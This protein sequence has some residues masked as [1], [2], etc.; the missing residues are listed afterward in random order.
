MLCSQSIE[1]AKWNVLECSMLFCT[2]WKERSTAWPLNYV[3]VPLG[4]RQQQKKRILNKLF[5]A[6]ERNGTKRK[7]K[8]HKGNTFSV[9]WCWCTFDCG[10]DSNMICS[11]WSIF[12]LY[13]S[14]GLYTSTQRHLCVRLFV[15]DYFFVVGRSCCCCCT[16]SLA[17]R[18]MFCFD[19]EMLLFSDFLSG[20]G[21]M[22]RPQNSNDRWIKKWKIELFENLESFRRSMWRVSLYHV[23]RQHTQRKLTIEKKLL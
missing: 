23:S 19:I 16:S 18:R 13:S 9:C 15:L 20:H 21:T 3:V 5:E 2:I 4:T 11:T 14:T 7:R 12:T 17:S 22:K 8:K 1:P 10:N 6:L